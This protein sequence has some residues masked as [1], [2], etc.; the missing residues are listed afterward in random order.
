MTFLRLI[1]RA[2]SSIECFF[3]MQAWRLKRY[4]EVSA[5]SPEE[6]HDDYETSFTLPFCVRAYVMDRVFL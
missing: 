6:I 4:K 1:R 3:T 5:C 2:R